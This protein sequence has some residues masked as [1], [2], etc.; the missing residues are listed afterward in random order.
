MISTIQPDLVILII[1]IYQLGIKELQ[2][3][4]L[5]RIL[6][7]VKL[8]IVWNIFKDKS[9]NPKNGVF[10]HSQRL[11]VDSILLI[12]SIHVNQSSPILVHFTTTLKNNI[13]AL[14]WQLLLWVGSLSSNLQEEEESYQSLD[15]M[16]DFSVLTEFS[17]NIFILQ[18]FQFLLHIIHFIVNFLVML[19]I[20]G[21]F[22]LED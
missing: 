6:R 13:I 22:M 16:A 8:Q 20:Y 10:V 12:D 2:L 9:M 21:Q 17:D 3:K 4:L 19:I 11:L 15:N 14:L 5:K 7:M 1:H 18:F